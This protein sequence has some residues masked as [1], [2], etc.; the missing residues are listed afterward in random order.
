MVVDEREIQ[1]FKVVF[2]VLLLLLL[3]LFD[4]FVPT[5]AHFLLS[6]D[7]WF[8]QIYLVSDLYL[9]AQQM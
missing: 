5:S 6:L 3:L 4:I 2:V 8:A 1:T 9:H 7:K